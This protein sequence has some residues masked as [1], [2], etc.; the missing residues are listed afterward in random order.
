MAKTKNPAHRSGSSW[1]SQ[2]PSARQPRHEYE[3]DDVAADELN[4]RTTRHRNFIISDESS[5]DSENVVES[6]DSDKGEDSEEGECENEEK[7]ETEVTPQYNLHSAYAE[8]REHER[9]P[10]VPTNG[11]PCDCCNRT[12]TTPGRR[13]QHL[14]SEARK[15]EKAREKAEKKEAQK[16]AAQADAQ[17]AKQPSAPAEEAPGGSEEEYIPVMGDKASTEK[18]LKWASYHITVTA[19][20]RDLSEEERRVLVSFAHR[21]IRKGALVAAAI[22]APRDRY[23]D[24]GEEEAGLQPVTKKLKK[25]PAKIESPVA[26]D[27]QPHHCTNK[28][29]TLRMRW[30]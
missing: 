22:F 23:F 26:D 17:Q 5:G 13:R 25:E 16:K 21:H 29:W 8:Q 30:K 3:D 10:P 15:K 7:E 24:L 20:S 2:T 4:P 19:T 11:Y 6:E 28:W 9:A 27:A 14:S 18:K 1:R 12:F